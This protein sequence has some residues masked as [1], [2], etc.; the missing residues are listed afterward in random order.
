MS[1][2][3]PRGHPSWVTG[4]KLTFLDRYSDDWQKAIDMGLT[5][6]GIFY[7]RVTKRFINRFGWHFDRWSDPEDDS[8]IDE[9]TLN[10][11]DPQDGLST[12]ELE[13]RNKYFREL[14][15]VRYAF[16]GQMMTSVD[17]DLTF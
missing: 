14:Q 5:Q 6:A 15:D 7:D 11:E 9:A 8:D 17:A 16:F 2:K 10:N 13:K 1:A 4:T 12:E 3:K